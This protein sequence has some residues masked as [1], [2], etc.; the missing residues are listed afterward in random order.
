MEFVDGAVANAGSEL[1]LA[2]VAAR[3][4]ADA[5]RPRGWFANFVD[6]GSFA[7][8]RI[9]G[10]CE[11]GQSHPEPS[12]ANTSGRGARFDLVTDRQ[13]RQGDVLG[14]NRCGE[15]DRQHHG[16]EQERSQQRSTW[17]V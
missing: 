7:A 11:T 9:L 5:A 10:G 1:A 2:V 13:V 4:S 15:A 16:S 6:I 8:V 12:F 14:V 17:H 3:A